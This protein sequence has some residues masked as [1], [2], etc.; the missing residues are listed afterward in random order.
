M[1]LEKI[2]TLQYL[3]CRQSTNYT[4]YKHSNKCFYYKLYSV[5]LYLHISEQIFLIV[6][7]K[8]QLLKVASVQLWKQ[9]M[10][11]T[12]SN[13]PL[14]LQTLLLLQVP[15]AVTLWQAR[16]LRPAGCASGYTSTHSPIPAPVVQPMTYKNVLFASGEWTRE[17]SNS[18]D[19]HTGWELR[20][21]FALCQLLLPLNRLGKFYAN[22][23]RVSA[24]RRKL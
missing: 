22:L 21:G 17:Y 6:Q 23:S 18:P 20:L 3:E 19:L 16:S 24:L 4:L 14:T 10:Y 9:T 12:H 2:L 8:I 15:P 7:F 1:H 5:I 13:C 11:T